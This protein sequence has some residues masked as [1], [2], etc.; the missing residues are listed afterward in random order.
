MR[1]LARW[2]LRQLQA[3]LVGAFRT[4]EHLEELKCRAWRLGGFGG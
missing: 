4:D 2:I 3:L 1:E